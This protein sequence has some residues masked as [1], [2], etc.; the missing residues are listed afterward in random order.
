MTKISCS[1][2]EF[3]NTCFTNNVQI[4]SVDCRNIAWKGNNMRLAFANCYSLQSITNISN[5]VTDMGGAFRYCNH[6]TVAPNIPNSVVSM[7]ETFMACSNL[8]EAPNL[9]NKTNLITL[10]ST[11][12]SCNKL[13]D[14]PVIPNSVTDLYMTFSD[15]SSLVNIP[16]LP[17]SVTSLYSTFSQCTNLKNAPVIPNAVTNMSETFYICP[18]L[19]TAPNIPSTVTNMEST[20]TRCV[21]LTGDIY[22]TSSEVTNAANCFN[23]T[24]LTKNVYIPYKYT[25][26]VFTA[27]Y[28]SFVNAGYTTNGMTNGVYLKNIIPEQEYVRYTIVSVPGNCLITLTADGYQQVDNYIEV[29]SGTEVSWKV[30]KYGYEPKQGTKIITENTM[31][32]IELALQVTFIITP[33]PSNALVQ[34]TADGYIQENNGITVKSGT[35]VNWRVTAIGYQE[36]SGSRVITED[37]TQSIILDEIV[38]FTIV[39]TPSDATITLNAT[40]Y[41]EKGSNWIKVPAGTVVNWTV[42][43]QFYISQGEAR[44]I[45]HTETITPQLI[46]DVKYEMDLDETEYEYSVSSTA[47]LSLNK[48]IGSA[49]TVTVPNIED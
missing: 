4:T 33:T 27:T 3:T 26:N 40:N 7:N 45:T 21:N 2:I 13:T 38:T 47:E 42:S 18:N 6:I 43:K 46:R 5:T 1:G 31:D 16:E 17:N 8:T 20:F 9:S 28:N 35:L 44:T 10:P 25:N 12:K 15:C 29:P 48:Y 14:A 19:V 39:P 49:T 41:I 30:E 23:G 36:K 22:I 11:F 32:N 34:L 24:A 37:L